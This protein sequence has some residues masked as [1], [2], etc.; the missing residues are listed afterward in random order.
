[1]RIVPPKHFQWNLQ[2]LAQGENRRHY[3]NKI[4][5]AYQNGGHFRDFL[6]QFITFSWF[7]WPVD[8]TL[9]YN[10]NKNSIHFFI[11]NIKINQI[12]FQL[13]ISSKSLQ[14][15]KICLNLSIGW[16][17]CRKEKIWCKHSRGE[18]CMKSFPQDIPFL[19]FRR[20]QGLIWQ[21]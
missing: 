17:D 21:W 15:S 13:L 4:V 1:M 3:K 16:D 7:P 6:S 18:I 11:L 2:S 20:N 8:T 5:T 19:L 9:N 10:K 14:S 12:I